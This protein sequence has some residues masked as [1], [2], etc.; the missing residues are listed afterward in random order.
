MLIHPEDVN[1]RMGWRPGTAERLARQRRLPYRLLPDGSIRFEWGEIE[2]L[3][4]R[5]DAVPPG[6]QTRGGRADA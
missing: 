5:V 2:P 6:P 4:V 3:I 1:R